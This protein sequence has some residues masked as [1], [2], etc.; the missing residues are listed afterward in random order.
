M[1]LVPRCSVWK[2]WAHEGGAKAIDHG[3]RRRIRQSKV[4]ALDG[5]AASQM[6]TPWL[7]LRWYRRVEQA[8][9]VK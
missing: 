9:S 5:V 2:W 8:M 7:K 1:N 4:S 3:A 6:A